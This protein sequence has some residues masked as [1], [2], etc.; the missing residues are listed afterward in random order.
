VKGAV[1]AYES[2]NLSDF[3]KL[4]VSS[5]NSEREL[6]ANSKLDYIPNS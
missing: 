2:E 4:V 1:K 6:K 3:V 5:S